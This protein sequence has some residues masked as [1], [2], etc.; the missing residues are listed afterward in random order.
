MFLVESAQPIER[1]K[2][3]VDLLK[4][5]LR[6]SEALALMAQNGTIDP[7]TP[8]WLAQGYSLK[9]VLDLGG[10]GAL[11]QWIVRME[12]RAIFMRVAESVLERMHWQKTWRAKSVKVLAV[13]LLSLLGIL[14]VAGLMISLLTPGLLNLAGRE[15]LPWI[16]QG[17][18]ALY[19]SPWA[20][21]AIALSCILSLGYLWWMWM[22]KPLLKA[23]SLVDFF[24][25]QAI[26]CQS[27]YRLV[28]ALEMSHAQKVSPMIK[29]QLA[30]L[31]HSM[32]LGL[33]FSQALEQ[34][35]YW[36]QLM[37]KR[38]AH[39]QQ[40]AKL[41]EVWRGLAVWMQEHTEN[42]LSLWIAL[43]P[44]MV[45]MV[46]ASVVLALGIGLLW[47]FYEQLMQMGTL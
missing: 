25:L 22:A 12:Q 3:L 35:D 4:S 15:S 11:G 30:R 18:I 19:E 8:Q 47:P 23:L 45:V 17:L 2:N 10:L 21:L 32:R 36:P 24:Q 37:R 38:F 14:G 31:F 26:Y 9:Q 42:Q 7:Q 43:M 33:T 40:G 5:G 29:P 1:L 13:P 34:S 28:E 20:A 44:Q 16:S 46:S 41:E 27:G 6:L 39:A